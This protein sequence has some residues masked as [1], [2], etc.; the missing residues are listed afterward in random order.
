MSESSTPKVDPYKIF[1]QGHS[2]Y[3]TLAVL[4]N[5]APNNEQLAAA[6]TEPSIVVGALTI[7][8]FFKCMIS[9]ES[10]KASKIHDLRKLYDKLSQPTRDRIE[11]G[12]SKI[13]A[14][15]GPEWDHYEQFTGQKMA[16]DLPT[17]LAVGAESFERIRYSYEGGN[18]NLQYY[19]QDLP[20]LLGR[21]ILAMKP[22]W[23]LPH[24]SFVELPP[25]AAR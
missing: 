23:K 13:A 8:L 1:V 17:A 3:Q 21:I 15:R 6:L 24:A 14:H 9:I 5:V 20:R 18:E 10:G 19:L 7:E 12:W 11:Q 4:C 16:R 22:D 25:F 2:F